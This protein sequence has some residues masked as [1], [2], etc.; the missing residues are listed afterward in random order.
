[1]GRAVVFA[2]GSFL[3]PGVVK[4]KEVVVLALVNNGESM[5]WVHN[6]FGGGRDKHQPKSTGL[7]PVEVTKDQ[8]TFLQGEHWLYVVQDVKSERW[9]CYHH[10]V[11]HSCQL[12]NTTTRISRSCSPPN[13]RSVSYNSFCRFL[14]AAAAPLFP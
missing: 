6:I 11:H 12:F 9:S 1:L 5:E 4:N 10:S 3:N 13:I 8:E 2:P 7:E 14:T